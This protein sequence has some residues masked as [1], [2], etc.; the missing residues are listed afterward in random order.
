VAVSF[1][2]EEEQFMA[3]V[4]ERERKLGRQ[5]AA[6][7]HD[8]RNQLNLASMQLERLRAEVQ[9]PIRGGGADGED[10][11]QGLADLSRSLGSARDLCAGTVVGQGALERR[12]VAL[13]QSLLTQARGAR[14]LAPRGERVRVLVRCPAD[15]V[16][17]GHPSHLDR[18]VKNL[19]LNAIEASPAGG[20]VRLAARAEGPEIRLDVI[21]QGRGMDRAA[22]AEWMHPGRSGSGG[23]GYGSASLQECLDELGGRLEVSSAPGKGTR[24]SVYLPCAPPRQESLLLLVDPDPR[25]RARRS[26]WLEKQGQ[27]VAQ[28]GSLEDARTWLGEASVEGVL[29]ARGLHGDGLASFRSA[30]RREGLEVSLVGV[31]AD[32]F[33]RVVKTA[34]R[35]SRIRGN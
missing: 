16:V 1:Q 12:R 33:Q 34:R 26:K 14:D 24:V 10:H 21:D 25:R 28:A 13:R 3:R 20:E 17:I 32:E 27:A 30:A 15:L 4:Q 35:R 11:A 9:V 19:I 18:L 31:Q 2:A 5:T 7:T 29:V 6:L 22:Q 23:T 8:L